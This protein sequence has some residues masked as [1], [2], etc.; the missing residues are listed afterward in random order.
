MRIVQV[1]WAPVLFLFT[2]QT[3]GQ[4][5]A[6]FSLVRKDK[7]IFI[8]ERW[9]T[10]PNSNPPIRARE[11]RGDFT[12]ACTISDAI[13]LIRNET[14]VKLWQD[15]V[16]EFKVYRSKDSTYWQEY[17]YHDIPWPVSDQDHFLEYKIDP[18][19]TPDKVFIS[20]NTKPDNRLAPVR[21]GVTR[22]TLYGQWKIE[23]IA[24]NKIRASYSIVS[25]PIGIPRFFTDPVVRNNLMSTIKAYIDVLEGRVK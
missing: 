10:F 16:S 11:V 4:D 23:K 5:P 15:H 9:I 21:E 14:K 6:K 3:F 7:R 8:Y 18:S 22:M 1:L 19:S 13:A 17:S 25:K 24:G 20:F 2:T 12:V